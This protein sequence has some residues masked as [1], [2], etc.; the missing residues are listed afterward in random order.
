VQ[1]RIEDSIG[2]TLHHP[3][4]QELSVL[5]AC[6]YETVEV[7]ITE[8]IE[9]LD[10]ADADSITAMQR[11]AAIM[12]ALLNELDGI[13]SMQVLPKLPPCRRRGREL[14][15]ERARAEVWARRAIHLQSSG[16]LLVPT[17]SRIWLTEI[18][19]SVDTV[20]DERRLRIYLAQ[21]DRTNSLMA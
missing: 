9:T 19:E 11:A 17:A 16:E 10:G 1:R 14:E 8:Y 13:L 4:Q 7:I 6:R 12:A 20:L 21:L 18:G 2:H 15:L 3:K 5:F